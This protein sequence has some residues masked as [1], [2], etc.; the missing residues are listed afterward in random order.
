MHHLVEADVDTRRTQLLGC[1]RPF[2][3]DGK[4]MAQKS[5]G[6]VDA[7]T[8]E[9]E[10]EEGKPFAGFENSR[11]E[12][13]FLETVTSHAAGNRG[14]TIED[15]QEGNPDAPRWSVELVKIVEEETNED[16]VDEGEE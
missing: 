4:G 1:R 12:R 6:T 9:E 5:L 3:V 13:L 2:D 10:N 11:P 8:A 15:D 14:D 7:D 16:V